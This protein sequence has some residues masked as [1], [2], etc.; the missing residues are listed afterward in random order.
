MVKGW[1]LIHADQISIAK[2]ANGDA[3]ACHLKVR[4][5]PAFGCLYSS[6]ISTSQRQTAGFNQLAGQNAAMKTSIVEAVQQCTT[7]LR[8]ELA[9][10]SHSLR[11]TNADDQ[12]LL[13]ETWKFQDQQPF[14]A[15]MGKVSEAT[16][17][18]KRPAIDQMLLDSLRYAQI[19][20]RRS[21]VP[22]AHK[23]T[24]RWVF[25]EQKILGADWTNFAS[26][27]QDSGMLKGL[28]WIEGKAG[29]GK[30]TLMR[31]LED[32]PQTKTH[33]NKWAKEKP[34]LTAN[35]F[36]WNPGTEIQKSQAGLLRSLLHGLL[37]QRPNAAS[38]VSPWRWRR[39]ES[40]REELDAWAVD[41]LL[42]A[43]RSLIS[44][45]QESV[46]VC[47]FVDGLDEFEGDD[48]TRGE[49]INL[50]KDCASYPYVK[51]CVS[52]RPWLIFR[53][54]F[55]D[56]PRLQLQHL[57]RNDIRNYVE[58]MLGQDR[59]FLELKSDDS[60]SC[61]SLISE[62]VNK[63]QGVFLWVMLVVRSLRQGLR[64][65]DR[66]S[67][68]QKRLHKIPSDLEEYFAQI[69][70][71]IDPF[72][73]YQAV[74]MFRLA[75]RNGNNPLTLM[76]L[77]FL[78]EDDENFALKPDWNAIQDTEVL[79][80]IHSITRRLETCTRGFLEAHRPDSDLQ[81]S[82]GSQIVDFLHRTV[83]DFLLREDIRSLLQKFES[84]RG[85]LD[86]DLF[87]FR[88]HLAQ[89]K[90]LPNKSLP[91]PQ[92]WG[93]SAFFNVGSECI[94][95][96]E[97]YI[98]R[99]GDLR[100]EYIVEVDRAIRR[101]RPDQYAQNANTTREGEIFGTDFNSLSSDAITSP[102]LR[103]YGGSHFRI[104]IADSQRA[105]KLQPS[106]PL[107]DL[108]VTNPSKPRLLPNFA[109]IRAV[110]EGGDKANQTICG[111]GM[112]V[113]FHYLQVLNKFSVREDWALQRQ[114]KGSV[115]TSPQ[116]WDAFVETAQL[117]LEHGALSKGNFTWTRDSPWNMLKTALGN[118]E[119][120]RVMMARVQGN[121]VSPKRQ[122]SVPKKEDTR[123]QVRK[124]SRSLLSLLKSH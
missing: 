68:L 20:E 77:S 10:L 30:S 55:E 72:Y 27:C 108:A 106:I 63:A 104:V 50:L 107:L 71:S 116:P 2:G 65:E 29:S 118:Q 103:M 32:E 43:F 81:G 24:F 76:T 114:Q 12:H 92:V 47:L 21:K 78:Q 75:Q 1:N 57:T 109:V 11:A 38:L 60:E 39:Y 31:Y 15:L 117:F 35:C 4:C 84:Q 41:E 100:L 94:S 44:T 79:A 83:Y 45:L 3:F 70:N 53:D 13:L 18:Q 34:I 46:C 61:E 14:T 122:D 123:S 124:G 87:L 7:E 26:W 37:E 52:S 89:L 88:A 112:T 120:K 67:D 25:D 51:V 59:K 93:E 97:T 6:L 86:L 82:F 66:F 62:V 48:E 115:K 16:E 73:R 101:H 91:L 121:S 95:H 40:G 69:F 90:M 5:T 28:Y 96:C 111:P 23:M 56:F 49:L 17:D 58:E 22:E 64:N 105:E 98:R 36:F 99:T 113:W 54:A 110:L 8:L 9:A 33:L 19:S 74:A 42:T 119:A 85:P 102:V 80:R